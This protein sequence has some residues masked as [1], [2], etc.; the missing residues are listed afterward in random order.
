MPT[1]E[2]TARDASGGMTNGVR[3][4]KDE[5]DL[6]R[7]L[8]EEGFTPVEVKKT[9]RV[10][11]KRPGGFSLTRVKLTDLSIF[12]RQFSTMIDAGVSIVRCLNVLAG[13]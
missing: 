2:F 10:K 1:F 13:V 11:E 5:V 12:C 4:A 9:V 3:D 8:R 7:V 6:A